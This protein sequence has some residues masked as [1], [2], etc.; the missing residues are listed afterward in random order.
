MSV[1]WCIF[2]RGISWINLQ[3]AR[4]A[5][6]AACEASNA[7][8]KYFI[9]WCSTA[10]MANPGPRKCSWQKSFAKLDHTS[11]IIFQPLAKWLS[12]CEKRERRFVFWASERARFTTRC[13][14]TY[15]WPSAYP[16]FATRHTAKEPVRCQQNGAPSQKLACF[17][18]KT[19]MYYEV[20]MVDSI[21]FKHFPICGHAKILK[22]VFN[23]I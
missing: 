5:L 17:V 3:V 2:E 11:A 18:H 9:F 21:L 8:H 4:T 12:K 13:F 6:G 23:T 19:K 20:T 16:D 7:A 22:S 10:K 15:W 1:V 14:I